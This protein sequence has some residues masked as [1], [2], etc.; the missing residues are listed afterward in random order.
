V[1]LGVAI[2]MD[3]KEQIL[4]DEYEKMGEKAH[5]IL[6]TVAILR[7][8]NFKWRLETQTDNRDSRHKEL[9]QL[10]ES[11]GESNRSAM[12]KMKQVE[13]D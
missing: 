1:N 2:E 13:M 5:K 6:H 7:E 9:S 3:E 8:F 12:L 4:D 11:L 10:L